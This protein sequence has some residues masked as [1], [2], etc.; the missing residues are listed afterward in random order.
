MIARKK[1]ILGMLRY[2]E[3]NS[4]PRRELVKRC[5][6]SDRSVRSCIAE[7]RND[8]IPVCSNSKTSGYFI[9]DSDDEVDHFLNE[10]HKRAMVL[11]S[12][13][14]KVSEGYGRTAYDY[15]LLDLVED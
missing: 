8:G 7:L 3:S 4:I 15:D 9:A 11:L 6:I 14:K 1:K 10:N 5:C 13:N 2:G 12:I